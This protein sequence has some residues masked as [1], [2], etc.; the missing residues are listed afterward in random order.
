MRQMQLCLRQAALH[1]QT[2]R[3]CN[4]P[5]VLYGRY[6]LR[7]NK[8]KDPSMEVCVIWHNLISSSYWNQGMIIVSTRWQEGLNYEQSDKRSRSYQNRISII[9]DELEKRFLEL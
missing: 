9:R 1:K 5:V 7:N 2:I 3:G 8:S 6:A 4:I